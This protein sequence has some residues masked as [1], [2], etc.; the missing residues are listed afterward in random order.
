MVTA[1]AGLVLVGGVAWRSPSKPL[2][3]CSASL[4][5][6]VSARGDRPLSRTGPDLPAPSRHVASGYIPARTVPTGSRSSSESGAFA[7]RSGMQQRGTTRSGTAAPAGRRTSQDR[8]GARGQR[9]DARRGLCSTPRSH[10]NAQVARLAALGHIR[11]RL[12]F[13]GVTSWVTIVS[14][15]WRGRRR[16]EPQTWS[17]CSARVIETSR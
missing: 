11:T 16:A 10:E 8:G 15:C 17:T 3:T 5:G 7:A 4:T 12:L 6:L 2:S 1:I 14:P 13:W 9:R